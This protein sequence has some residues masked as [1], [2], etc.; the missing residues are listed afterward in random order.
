MPSAKFEITR[1]CKLCRKSFLAKTITS[2][3]C[4]RRCSNLAYKKKDEKLIKLRLE[5]AKLIPENQDYISVSDAVTLYDVGK[6]TLYRLI[7]KGQ[8]RNYNLGTRLIRVCREDLE[9]QFDLIPI[10]KL[11]DKKVNEV[12]VFRLEK[13]NCYTIGEITKIFGISETTVYM[14]IRKY[15]IPIRQIGKYVYA[16]KTEIDNLY[17]G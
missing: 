5:K 16:P 7:R 1:E 17:K 8:I 4:S 12:K 3:Y 6:N 15:S 14:H 11:K 2:I 9:K 10:T 13:E